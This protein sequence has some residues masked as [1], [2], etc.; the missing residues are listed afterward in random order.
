[1]EHSNESIHNSHEK[2]SELTCFGENIIIYEKTCNR[3]LYCDT[4]MITQYY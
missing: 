4:L 2:V 3:T 1:M